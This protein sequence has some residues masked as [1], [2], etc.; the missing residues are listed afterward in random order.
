MA[1]KKGKTDKVAVIEENEKIYGVLSSLKS[2]KGTIKKFEKELPVTSE[3]FGGADSERPED[4]EE[5]RMW[6]V[7]MGSMTGDDGQPVKAVRLYDDE[8]E[9][10]YICASAVV[11]STLESFAHQVEESGQPLP[12]ALIKTGEKTKGKNGSYYKWEISILA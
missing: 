2:L 7:G 1:D 12:V 11:V 4:G 3:Y 8:E 5:C 9:K 6:F 10:F